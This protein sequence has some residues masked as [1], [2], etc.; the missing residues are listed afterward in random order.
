M[1]ADFLVSAFGG[2]NPKEIFDLLQKSTFGKIRCVALNIG[3]E[4]RSRN[5][6][7]I[8]PRLPG[9]NCSDRGAVLFRFSGV[10]TSPP[11]SVRAHS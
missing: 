3:F 9:R 1:I 6:F 10:L 2:T 4:N 11:F 8:K 7:T 5:R